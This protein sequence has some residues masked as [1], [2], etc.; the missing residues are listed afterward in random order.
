MAL[1]E[2]HGRSVPAST[3]EEDEQ[4]AE[5]QADHLANIRTVLGGETRVRT[6][7]VLRRLVDLNPD[8]YGDWSFQD[9]A[10]ALADAGSPRASPTV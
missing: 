7:V 6:Q 5:V 2:E 8:E 1:L 9:L 10:S 4:D 3:T